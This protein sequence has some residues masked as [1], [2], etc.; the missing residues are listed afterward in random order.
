[1][2]RLTERLAA[3]TMGRAMGGT[4]LAGGN[5]ARVAKV[6]MAWMMERRMA[7]DLRMRL[8]PVVTRMER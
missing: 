1:M 7:L 5:R 3:Q 8:R 4:A 6:V 2:A